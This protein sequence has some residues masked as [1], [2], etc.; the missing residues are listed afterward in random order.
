MLQNTLGVTVQSQGFNGAA[1]GTMTSKIMIRGAQ[2]GTLVL[3]N[4]VPM[5]MD[6]KYN[7]EDIPSGA[8]EKIEIV[9]GG[10]SVLYGSEATGG[11]INII[12]KKRINNK[13]KFSAQAGALLERGLKRAGHEVMLLQ[14]DDLDA[15]V[16]A[17]NDWPADIFVSL[18]CNA[19]PGRNARGTETLYYSEQGR[20]LGEA[21]QKKIL[22]KVPTIDRGCKERQGLYVLRRTVM[23]AILVELAFIDNNDDLELLEN[24]MP[25]FAGAIAAGIDEYF[26]QAEI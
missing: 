25:A 13:V 3:L 12:T 9:R 16:A 5:N 23:T 18:H 15:V 14:S 6:G 19:S 7:L 4:G 10:G 26:R 1:M 2:V 11:V 20:L 21:V 17:A 24:D 22:S 8:I